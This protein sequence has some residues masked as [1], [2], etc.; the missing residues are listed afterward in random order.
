[1]WLSL[2]PNMKKDNFISLEEYRNKLLINNNIS[3]VSD[4]E[5]LK[6][7]KEIREKAKKKGG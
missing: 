3:D 2:Y 6:E 7:V 1:M 4:E 5:I